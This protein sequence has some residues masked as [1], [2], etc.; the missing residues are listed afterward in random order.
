MAESP[1]PASSAQSSAPGGVGE[2]LRSVLVELS[3]HWGWFVG[4]AIM[5]MVLGL[6]AL[7]YTVA[8][9]VASVL[10]IGI[11]MVI[12]GIA[13]L[14]QAWRLKEWR[15]FLLWTIS[16]LAYTVAGAIALY[17]PMV[18]AAVLTLFL[19]A[20]L[21]AS[22]ALRLWVWWQHRSQKGWPWLA[23]S[24]V[25]T[26]VAGLLVAMS[27]PGSS[28][29]VLGLLLGIDLWFQGLSVLMVGLALRRSH[30]N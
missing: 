19:G 10:F 2:V 8:A 28:L 20:F 25:L 30:G 12:A 1:I 7:A 22:G 24:G 17:D 21:I 29:W 23:F 4:L 6:L 13:Q 11:L 5:M 15:G 18:G 14:L 3:P 9:T 27:W 16:G 26:L